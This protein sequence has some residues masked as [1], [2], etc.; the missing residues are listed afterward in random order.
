MFE[1]GRTSYKGDGSFSDE[2]APLSFVYLLRCCDEA[3]SKS[4]WKVDRLPPVAVEEPVD[5]VDRVL[6]FRGRISYTGGVI[7]TGCCCCRS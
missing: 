5:A 7:V 3:S 2:K 1:R 4:S 6:T